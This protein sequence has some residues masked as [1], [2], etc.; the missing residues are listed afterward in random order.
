MT[1]GATEASPPDGG[2]PA[3][4]I[5]ETVEAKQIEGRSL[6]QIAWARL[7]KDKI[8]LISAIIIVLIILIAICAP[9][10]VKISG[11]PPDQPNFKDSH[12]NDL[13][14]SS[15][16]G[17]PAGGLFGSGMSTEHWLGVEPQNGRDVFARLVYGARS[18]LLVALGG[19]VVAVVLGTVIGMVAGYFRGWVDALISRLMDILLS[20]PTLLFILALTPVIAD[21]AQDTFG[22][23]DNNTLRMGV[24]IFVL[25]FFGWAYLARIV[26]GQ[27]LSIREREFIDAAR[28]LGAGPG[29][30]IFKQIL[31]NL[32]P[33][34][35]VY[36]TLIIPTYITAEAALSFLG[37]G[38]KEPTSSWGRMIS[39]A[40]NW[41]E[42][43]PLYL[44]FPGA[45]LFITVLAFN[46]LGD[47]VRDALDP[48]AGRS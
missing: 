6:G 1:L 19:T 26:R 48:R 27:T 4:H 13:L 38:V 33:T 17:I 21:R 14:D 35:L 15:L 29:Y 43:N 45:M 11:F 32:I 30:V 36:S 23:P 47:S 39:D 16:G 2:L 3:E 25:G 24:L 40:S 20:F 37:V 10:I 7:R 46:L 8:A 12:G 44:F 22:I 18:S 42:G 28:S 5:A 9:L 34:L 41:Y 31:P